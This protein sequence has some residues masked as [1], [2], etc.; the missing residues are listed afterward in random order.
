MGVRGHLLAVVLAR[1]GVAPGWERGKNGTGIV[2]PRLAPDE[3]CS[4]GGWTPALAFQ[5]LGLQ[6]YTATPCYYYCFSVPSLAF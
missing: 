2:E 4:G 1:R 5:V 3:L 6:G